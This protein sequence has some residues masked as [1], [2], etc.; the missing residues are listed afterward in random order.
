MG[1]LLKTAQKAQ[2]NESIE[3]SDLCGFFLKPWE[4]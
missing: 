1:G 4:L 2:N 3:W